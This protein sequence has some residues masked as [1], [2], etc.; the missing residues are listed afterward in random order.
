MISTSGGILVNRLNRAKR[1][2]F[3]MCKFLL[4]ENS[5]KHLPSFLF[6]CRMRAIPGPLWESV[7]L[8]YTT[9]CDSQGQPLQLKICPHSWSLGKGR[10][11]SCRW[12]N[13]CFFFLT[14]Y[15]SYIICGQ[16]VETSTLS[17]LPHVQT[18][19]KMQLIY[20][21]KCEDEIYL[22]KLSH[23]KCAN[24]FVY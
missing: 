20:R 8:V 17:L 24:R 11:P 18:Y 23:S 9:V 4:E 2:A 5:S 1:E 12:D 19:A 21:C 13:I 22:I 7:E 16:F 6:L 15:Y 14:M 10:L 3:L